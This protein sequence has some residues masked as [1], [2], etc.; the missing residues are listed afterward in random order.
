MKVELKLNNNTVYIHKDVS[1]DNMVV[2]ANEINYAIQE[3][4]SRSAYFNKQEDRESPVHPDMKCMAVLPNFSGHCGKPA[5]GRID[6][7]CLCEECIIRC[8][9]GAGQIMGIFPR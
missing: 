2:V 8:F 1:Y 4:L 9:T 3:L 5:T 6:Y 7:M